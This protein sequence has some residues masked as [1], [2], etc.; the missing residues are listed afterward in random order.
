MFNVKFVSIGIIVEGKAYPEASQEMIKL[1]LL[2][3]PCSAVHHKPRTAWD[4][5]KWNKWFSNKCPQWFLIID[6]SAHFSLHQAVIRI[7]PYSDKR[8]CIDLALHLVVFVVA[9]HGY[10]HVRKKGPSATNSRCHSRVSRIKWKTV[11]KVRLLGCYSLCL[12]VPMGF[13][14]TIVS[15]GTE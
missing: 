8:S 14:S 11:L 1:L 6:G 12:V 2:L 15:Q 7:G 3:W 13:C 4:H 5:F 10:I 9:P